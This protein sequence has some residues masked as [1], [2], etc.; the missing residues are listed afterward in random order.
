MLDF[1]KEI[2]FSDELETTPSLEIPLQAAAREIAEKLSPD[3]IKKPFF[4]TEF[5]NLI[6]GIA[7]FLH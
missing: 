5:N 7:F 6:I 2:D 3:M 1:S 4:D